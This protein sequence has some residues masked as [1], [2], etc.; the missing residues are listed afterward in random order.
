MIKTKWIS[1]GV[2]L[3]LLCLLAMLALLVTRC[4][5]ITRPTA[6]LTNVAVTNQ[7]KP[8][9]T[10][11]ANRAVSTTHV[12]TAAQAITHGDWLTF[13]DSEAG[14]S[15]RYPANFILRSGKSK[16]EMYSTT[17]IIFNL[18]NVR[19]QEMDIQVASNPNNLPVDAVVK[20]IYEDLA[21]KPLQ[22]QAAVTL[23]K[24]TVAGMTAYKTTMLP[25]SAI[26]RF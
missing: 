9:P 10:V 1:W 15:M 7:V 14:Y 18:P 22:P 20:V 6:P 13:T 16:G 24:M 5:P 17:R 26:L 11:I 3:G 2:S 12:L 8:P 23:E 4:T 21:N 19:N 25:E